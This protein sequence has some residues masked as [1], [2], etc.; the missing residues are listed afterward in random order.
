LATERIYYAEIDALENLLEGHNTQGA[1]K[2]GE[3][4]FQRLGD[5]DFIIESSRVAATLNPSKC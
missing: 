5:C 2:A 3:Y 4:H 1:L